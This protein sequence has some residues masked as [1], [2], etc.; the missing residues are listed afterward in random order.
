MTQF[1]WARALVLGVSRKKIIAPAVTIYEIVHAQEA[2]S[3]WLSRNK[4]PQ[5]IP[6][7]KLGCHILRNAGIP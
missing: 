1:D 7:C 2:K 5:G 4:V 3:Y 6:D